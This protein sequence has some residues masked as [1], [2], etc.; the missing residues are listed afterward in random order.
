MKITK[1]AKLKIT[2]H[3]KV[4]NETTNLNGLVLTKLDG[5]GKGG[6]V[7]SITEKLQLPILYVTFGESIE[8]I[9]PFD[10]KEYV[11]G[12]FE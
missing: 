11:K 1:T 5:T 2:S 3:S 8:D 9:S 12:L 7:F 4:F 6:I 10:V